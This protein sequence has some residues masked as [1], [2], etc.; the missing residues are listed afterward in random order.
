MVGSAREFENAAVGFLRS[1]EES[2]LLTD[3]A[4]TLLAAATGGR[5]V[6]LLSEIFRE[7]AALLSRRFRLPTYVRFW[8]LADIS[9]GCDLRPLYPR[10]RTSGRW[11]LNVCF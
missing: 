2:E 10:K 6:L 11:S 8:L 9:G 7:A 1:K 3:A 4:Q 5:V